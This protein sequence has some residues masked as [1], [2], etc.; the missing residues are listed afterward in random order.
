MQYSGMS[1]ISDGASDISWTYSWASYC[2]Y[3]ELAHLTSCITN[4]FWTSEWTKRFAWPLNWA[5]WRTAA[6]PHPLK[7]D[8]QATHRHMEPSCKRRGMEERVHDHEL[9]VIGMYVVS[10]LGCTPA[11]ENSFLIRLKPSSYKI[12]PHTVEHWILWSSEDIN[13]PK[14]IQDSG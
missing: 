3:E 13:I 4:N 11:L 8:D 10:K 6:N 9:W 5:N 7:T 1:D 2:S 12:L 14:L